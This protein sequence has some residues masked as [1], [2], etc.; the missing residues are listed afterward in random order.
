MLIILVH[1]TPF[2]SL[3]SCYSV[4][5]M[6]PI[7]VYENDIL[8]CLYC[9]VV[10]FYNRVGI[11]TMEVPTLY[12]GGKGPVIPVVC[13]SHTALSGSYKHK[14]HSTILELDA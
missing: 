1:V 7:L 4:A 2:L 6:L 8:Q 10:F 5:S 12:V 13:M 3:S 9:G 14:N 11:V